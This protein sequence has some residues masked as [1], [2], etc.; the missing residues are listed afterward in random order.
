MSDRNETNQH[1]TQLI[2]IGG[3][4]VKKINPSTLIVPG[5]RHSPDEPQTGL[6]TPKAPSAGPE[7]HA[8]SVTPNNSTQPTAKRN[9]LRRFSLLGQADEIEANAA[10]TKP[11]LGKFIMLGQATMIYAEPNTGKTLI[12]LRLCLDAIEALRIDPNNLYYVNA[13]DSS[14]GLSTKVR[15]MQDVGAHMLVP[16]YNGF[17]TDHLVK[18]LV[19]AIEEGA[20]RGTCVIIDT[21]K[22][23]TDLMHKTRTSEFAQICRRYVMAGGTIIALGHT[24]KNPNADGTPR[25]QGTTDILDDFDS[26][27]MAQPMISKTGASQKVV[28]FTRKKSRADCPEIVAYA[29]AT[30]TGISYEEKLASV[31]IIDPDELDDFTIQHEDVSDPQVMHVIAQLITAG[32]VLGKMALAKAAAAECGISHRSALAVLD[33][34]TGTIPNEHLWTFDRG[35]RGVRNYRRID[36]TTRPS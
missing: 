17:R 3:E 31:Q 34:Y 35:P 16:G 30:A 36:Q 1:H 10:E 14:A 6:N 33:R 26:V 24:T 5:H 12:T 20:A 29:Y 22:K 13:D 9:P 7:I 27:Y 11:L 4:Q 32:S 23:F 28:K 19:Q 25:Y 2:E 15:L 18:L 21:L 8:A